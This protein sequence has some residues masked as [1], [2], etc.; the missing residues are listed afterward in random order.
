MSDK[1]IITTEQKVDSLWPRMTEL[2]D[3]VEQQAR[4]IDQLFNLIMAH[5]NTTLELISGVRSSTETMKVILDLIDPGN[6]E[7]RG[8]DVTEKPYN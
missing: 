6:A 8:K 4:L 5:R 7:F 3:R 1:S 2:E